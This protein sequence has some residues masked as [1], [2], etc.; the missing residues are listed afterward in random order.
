MVFHD[1][2]HVD[3][4]ELRDRQARTAGCSTAEDFSWGSFKRWGQTMA[5]LRRKND[6]WE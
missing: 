1:V 4:A 2:R 3:G 5:G 6:E